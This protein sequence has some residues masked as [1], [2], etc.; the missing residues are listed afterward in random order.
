VW[1]P[2]RPSNHLASWPQPPGPHATE[3]G[4]QCHGSF[5]RKP[6]GDS[7][8]ACPPF[9]ICRNFDEGQGWRVHDISGRGH[10]LTAAE[11]PRWEVV[12]WLSV[13]G[14]G[15]LGAGGGSSAVA[16][17]LCRFGCLAHRDGGLACP[18]RQQGRVCDRQ[19]SSCRALPPLFSER[20]PAG[21]AVS[22]QA[23]S[24]SCR[25]Q[26]CWKGW[27]SVTTAI[28][29]AATD[30]LQ[31]ARWASSGSTTV[32]VQGIPACAAAAS[33]ACP[34]LAAIACP[35]NRQQSLPS[36]VL[37]VP[38]AAPHTCRLSPA[39]AAPRPAL[40]CAPTAAALGP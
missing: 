2:Q 16:L 19:P 37:S 26:A 3:S 38:Y 17:L 13:C 8:C 6:K 1:R 23:C 33:K 4:A 18:A 12:R 34:A 15:G 35:G 11:T 7:P 22:Y 28:P 30:A 20:F 29:A 5:S 36:R 39:G 14:N 32:A 25:P 10:D 21:P 31:S 40:L 24:P 27:R 9:A